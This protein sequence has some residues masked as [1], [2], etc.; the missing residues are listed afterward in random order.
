MKVRIPGGSR[1]RFDSMV[2]LLPNESTTGAKFV[3]AE[4]G[5]TWASLAKQGG[6]SA[7][8]LALYNPKVKPA[9]KTGRIA[10]GTKLLVPTPA[11]VS[12][13]LSVPDPA[14]ERYGR[15]S[16]TRTH[17]VRRGEN[18]STIAKRYGTSSVAIM[19]LNR[20][21]KPLI[22]PGQELLV[23]GRAAPRSRPQTKTIARKR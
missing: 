11:V 6:I 14:I 16:G 3:T 21:K 2:A 10:A 9:P 13:A 4:K 15:T 23:N 7:R 18:L 12:A 5:A 8:A 1:A 19:R 20:L 17:I 22:F